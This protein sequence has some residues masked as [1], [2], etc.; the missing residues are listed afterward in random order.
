MTTLA[1]LT[2]KPHTSYSAMT[3]YLDCGEK[4]RLQRVLG[5]QGDP[6][7]Y[8]AGGS[9]VHHATEVYDELIEDRAAD[10]PWAVETAIA[11][12]R[13]DFQARLDEQPDAN[14]RAGGRKTAALPNG[15]DRNWW[16]SNGV[17][18]VQKYAEW[19]RATKHQFKIWRSEAGVLGVEVAVDPEFTG[20]VVVKGY[21]DRVFQSGDE[22]IIVDL[23][24]GKN[25][26][27]SFLQLGLYKVALEK[28]YGVKARFGAYYMT[29]KGE[30]GN[31]VDLG[32]FTE[33]MLARQFRDFKKGV[34]AEI[35][36]P[37]VSMMC[38]SCDVRSACYAMNP[39]SEV[40][41]DFD[42]DIVTSLQEA[43]A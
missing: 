21:I 40:T 36:V 30:L 27:A 1:D 33:S 11:A 17:L 7:Y 37:H 23:K 6:A 5:I 41:P 35:F 25:E 42:S 18:Q 38:S 8:L 4:F 3:T 26:P 39:A 20:G 9:A 12:F 32:R 24:S 15:E 13:N 34:E 19:R 16:L 43:S 31:L 29:R 28:E 2:G 10:F 22:L 14:W